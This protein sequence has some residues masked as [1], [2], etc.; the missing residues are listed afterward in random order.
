MGLSKYPQVGSGVDGM[1]R[2]GIGGV[3]VILGSGCR[4]GARKDL[5]L[6]QPFTHV[7]GAQTKSLVV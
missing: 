2:L 1:S 5:L 4:A 3:S 7:S 6:E